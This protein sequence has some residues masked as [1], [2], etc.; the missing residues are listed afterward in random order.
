MYKDPFVRLLVSPERRLIRHF[1]ILV[2]LAML[3]Y[4][5]DASEYPPN[6]FLVLMGGTLV[7]ILVLP[8]F[9]M[10]L[11]VPRYLFKGKYIQYVLSTL[12]A[13]IFM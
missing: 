1:S 5:G 4:S 9:N 13:V 11:L 12:A 10:Y 2:L 8:Y 6:M 7:M 3:V